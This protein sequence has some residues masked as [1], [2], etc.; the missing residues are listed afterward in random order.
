MPVFKIQHVTK[1]EYER[2]VKE[3]V[4]EIRVFPIHNKE[5]EVL[6]HDLV[7]TGA[8]AVYVYNDY[9]GNRTGLFNLLPA[10]QELV[11]DSRLMVRTL[12]TAG[13]QDYGPVLKDL[14]PGINDDLKLL[15]LSTAGMIRSQESILQIIDAVHQPGEGI[16]SIIQRCGKYIFDHFSYTKGITDT[17]TTVDEILEH[18]G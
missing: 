2:S 17:E 12:T 14:E 11:I 9:W 18:R 6:Q 5:Q 8:P 4:N 3:S 16:A 10:H 7:I 15:E 1:Y 13:F